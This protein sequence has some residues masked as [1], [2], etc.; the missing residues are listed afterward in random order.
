MLFVAILLFILLLFTFKKEFFQN[1]IKLGDVGC[2]L[3]VIKSHMGPNFSMLDVKTISVKGFK[4][5]VIFTSFNKKTFSTKMY[6]ALVDKVRVYDIQE[7]VIFF[8]NVYHNKVEHKSIGLHDSER[9]KNLSF[10]SSKIDGV[11]GTSYE[12]EQYKKFLME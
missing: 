11:S 3:N 5:E 8:D 4:Y 10:L 7:D 6:K 1:K 9:L 12:S 2:V